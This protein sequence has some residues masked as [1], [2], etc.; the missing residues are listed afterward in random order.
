MKK[1]KKITIVKND[2]SQSVVLAPSKK[3]EL[4]NIE[5]TDY[6]D[7]FLQIS[8]DAVFINDIN[9]T[10]PKT[11]KVKK[12]IKKK[13]IKTKDKDNNKIIENKN[14]IN[15]KEKLKDKVKMKDNN[16]NNSNVPDMVPGEINKKKEK[17]SKNINKGK[18]IEENKNKNDKN[19]KQEN[20]EDK[21]KRIISYNNIYLMIKSKIIFEL[22][23]SF[24][25][26]YIFKKMEKCQINSAKKI[27]NAYKGYITRK[28]LKLNYLT[29]KILKFRD[30]CASK[31]IAHYKGYKIRKLSKDIL[32]KKEDNYIIYSTLSDNTQLYF[33]IRYTIGLEDNIYFKF[34]ELLKCFVFY[35]SRRDKNFSKKKV[36][37]FFYN[38]KYQKLTDDMYEKNEK[39]EN[40]LNFPK[41]LKQNDL[42]SE[43]Y[44]KIINEYIKA[45]RPVTRKRENIIDYE[46]RKKKA[47]D[48]DIIMNN[49]K[50]GEKLNKM[51]RSKSFMRLKGIMK[52]KGILKPSKSYINLR[53]DDKKIQFGK[54]KIK[55]YHIPRK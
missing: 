4:Q 44:D 51:S 41:I 32:K 5:I 3:L 33:K 29:K 19:I 24:K 42:N 16:N 50:C 40:I 23:N 27:S 30:L 53:C 52:S 26:L 18:K 49:K 47:L 37:G 17:I 45:N 54:A 8:P 48:D 25:I 21:D 12:I 22:L 2:L 43:K 9:K 7:D 1:Q 31:I 34:C 39:G 55:G 20:E 35:I 46:E 28:Y 10:A 36:E 15:D 38:Q 13:I 11:K 14:N 6:I